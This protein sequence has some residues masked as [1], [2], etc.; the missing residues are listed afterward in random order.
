MPPAEEGPPTRAASMAADAMTQKPRKTRRTG[1]CLPRVRVLRA[2]APCVRLSPQCQVAGAQS[3]EKEW[4]G[5]ESCL[6]GRGSGLIVMRSR[7][8]SI[9]A[10]T[11][12][13]HHP[14]TLLTGVLAELQLQLLQ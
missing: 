5:I 11:F 10:G 4:N 9:T 14:M 8:K 13:H 1:G 7:L 12:H 6:R 2:R 3:E